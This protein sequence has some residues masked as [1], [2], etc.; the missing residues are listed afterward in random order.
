MQ[1]FRTTVCIAAW[2]M[3]AACAHHTVTTGPGTARPSTGDVASSSTSVSASSSP[4]SASAHWGALIV[5]VGNGSVRGRVDIAP[6]A[7]RQSA[8]MLLVLTGLDADAKYVW[9]I[10]RGL[11]TE[12]EAAGPP[13][14]YAPLTV[15]QQGRGSSTGTFPTADPNMTGYH[16]DIHVVGGSVV[17]CGNIET[18]S[19]G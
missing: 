16:L 17:A 7:G 4:V 19:K 15:D 18:A 5:P 3:T 6:A 2:G 11:C 9:H 1:T 12:T 13:S 14:E 10:R 8:A